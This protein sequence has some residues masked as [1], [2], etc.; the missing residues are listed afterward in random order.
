MERRVDVGQ[1]IYIGIITAVLSAIFLGA[2]GMSIRGVEKDHDLELRVVQV[3]QF[4][5]NQDKLNQKLTDFLES[6]YYRNG[7]GGLK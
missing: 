4:V 3:E 5:R 2:L 7:N 6:G 1:K